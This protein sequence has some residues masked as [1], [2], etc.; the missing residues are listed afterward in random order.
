MQLALVLC[1]L[2]VVAV[3]CD[4]T[5]NIGT[6]TSIALTSAPQPTP[7][8]TSARLSTET[9]SPSSTTTLIPP[10]QSPNCHSEPSLRSG[11]SFEAT[12]ITFENLTSQVVTIYWL[13]YGGER[14][15]YSEVPPG[16]GV[17]Q[18]T[19]M[20]HPW[21]VADS[22]GR[23]IDIYLPREP[24]EPGINRLMESN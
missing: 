23:C 8:P 17:E 21:L 1:A 18:P 19:Y 14:Q 11:P 7:P 5:S 4:Q 10:L 22:S 16:A 9:P 3:A 12:T 15:L 6:P 24:E 13:D 2:L 20:G